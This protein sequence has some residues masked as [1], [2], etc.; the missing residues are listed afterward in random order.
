MFKRIP[1]INKLI[2]KADPPWL[3]KGRG[4]PVTGSMPTTYPI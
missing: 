3:I 2:I 4:I 1:I